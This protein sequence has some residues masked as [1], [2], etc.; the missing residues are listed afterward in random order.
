MNV[1]GEKP[2]AHIGFVVHPSWVEALR[3]IGAVEAPTIKGLASGACVPMAQNVDRMTL[4]VKHSHRWVAII[5]P[6]ASRRDRGHFSWREDQWR[7]P[8]TWRNSHIA[9]LLAGIASSGWALE[10]SPQYIKA[11]RQTIY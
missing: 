2:P 3:P 6:C 1:L 10:T 9:V 4:N 5:C 8:H 7:V 11:A